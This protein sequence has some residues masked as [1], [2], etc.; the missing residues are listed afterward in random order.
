MSIP[1]TTPSPEKIYPGSADEESKTIF[2]MSINNTAVYGGYSV[3]SPMVE[4]GVNVQSGFIPESEVAASIV[5]EVVSQVSAQVNEITG[6]L[7]NEEGDE[8][9]GG[10]F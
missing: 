2:D 5:E 1:G 9:D 8:L 6:D 10:A 4:E 3:G 7:L